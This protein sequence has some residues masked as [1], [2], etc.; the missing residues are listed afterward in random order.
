M[1][2]ADSTHRDLGRFAREIATMGALS[3][4]NI[5]Q[6]IGPIWQPS[7][8]LVLEWCDQ[9]SA[10]AVLSAGGTL[11]TKQV[12]TDVSRGM[13]YLHSHGIIH[14]DLK[15]A[16]VLITADGLAKVGDFGLFALC[17]DKH[18]GRRRIRGRSDGDMS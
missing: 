18:L 10:H 6:T 4:P 12:V 17:G 1:P 13:A 3:H 9:G 2:S 5:V 11:D 16:N 15:A 8:M 7:M 14:R